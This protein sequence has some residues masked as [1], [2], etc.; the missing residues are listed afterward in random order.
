MVLFLVLSTPSLLFGYT[1]PGSGVLVYQ[2]LVASFAGVAWTAR[3]F[4]RRFFV[5][6]SGQE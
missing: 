1:D 2:A 4:L 3:K 6:S 5:K